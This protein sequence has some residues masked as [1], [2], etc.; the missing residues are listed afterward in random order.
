VIRTSWRPLGR[1]AALAATL[2]LLVIGVAT[3]AHAETAEEHCVILLGDDA[4]TV[5]CA[6][7]PDAA[8]QRFTAETGYTVTESADVVGPLVV[9]S[10]AQL[11][12]D[13]GYGGSSYLITRGTACNGVTLS[14]IADLGTIGLNDAVSSFTT[15]STCTVR[16]FVDINYGG[17]SYGYATSQS[18][19]PTF[20]DVASSARAR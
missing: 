18:S 8:V 12:A 13:A 10:I 7:T 9:Y 15:Y 6:E 17:S 14:S 4:D 20:N 16:L 11:F 5:V 3:P 19:L 2:A 1:A